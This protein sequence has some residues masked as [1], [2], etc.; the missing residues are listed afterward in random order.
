VPDFDACERL[1][2]GAFAVGTPD[3]FLDAAAAIAALPD[4]RK[5]LVF[6]G[7]SS[8]EVADYFVRA[9]DALR[10]HVGPSAR[11]STG[12]NNREGKDLFDAVSGKNIE[13]KSGPARTDGNAGLATVAWALGDEGKDA[14][15]EA[16]GGQALQ[17]RRRL[18][19]A[20][21]MEGR[22]TPTPEIEALKA[23]TMDRFL[24]YC[25]E[26][27]TVGGSAPPRLAH[28]ARCMASGLTKE[29]EVVGSFEPGAEVPLPVLL[30]A[31]WDEGLVLYGLAFQLDEELIVSQIARND[32]RAQVVVQGEQSGT[33]VLIYPHFRNSYPRKPNK[34][35]PEKI[36]AANWV[37]SPSFNIWVRASG[38]DG[39]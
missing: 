25:Q 21:L 31:S 11:F 34:E 2:R 33:R 22:P 15:L 9:D 38:G 35:Y 28:F 12:D 27:L 5:P 36:P 26:R 20:A 18:A 13:L 1:F 32:E 17:S 6:K 23:N 7:R 30:E 14:L 10:V 24:S 29:E 4:D 8:D 37:C 39:E 3:G 16:L 19:S